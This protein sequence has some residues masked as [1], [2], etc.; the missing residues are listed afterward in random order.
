MRRGP[1][2]G[3]LLL[4]SCLN[5]LSSASSTSLRS[6]F[7][8]CFILSP[9]H[10]NALIILVLLLQ[11]VWI[12][13]F[14]RQN[15]RHMPGFFFPFSVC[16]ITLTFLRRSKLPFICDRSHVVTLAVSY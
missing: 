16:R 10:S 13:E 6:G 14:T 12:I 4:F 2:I 9:G 7:Q 3:T 8:N 11:I 15:S 5:H 1:L